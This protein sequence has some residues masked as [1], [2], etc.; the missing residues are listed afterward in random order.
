MIIALYV[1]AGIILST[2][3]ALSTVVAWASWPTPRR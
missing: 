3:L 2:I 1:Y